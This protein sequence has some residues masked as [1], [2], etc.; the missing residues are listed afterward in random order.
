MNVEQGSIL[1]K[2]CNDDAEEMQEL[3]E[4]I[5]KSK[6]IVEFVLSFDKIKDKHGQVSLTTKINKSEFSINYCSYLFDTSYLIKFF[7]DIINLKEDIVLVLDNEGIEP[8]LYASPNSTNNV[9]FIFAHDYDLF[10]NTDI[11]EYNISDYKIECDII[12]DKKE[13]LKRFYNI[14]YPLVMNY[15]LKNDDKIV[16]NIENGKK[17]LKEI[18]KFLNT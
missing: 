14:I 1:F 4:L 6:P 11:S 12:I 9:R 13:L 5:N 18:E 7:A 8:I 3:I 16:Y 2:E 10:L 17:Y 15:N